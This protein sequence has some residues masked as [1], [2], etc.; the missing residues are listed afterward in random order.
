MAPAPSIAPETLLSEQDMIRRLTALYQEQGEIYQQILELSRLQ[1]EM[2]RG[3]RSLGEIRQVLQKKNVCLEIVKRL[4]L[5]ERQA[6]RQ[7]EEGKRRWSAGSQQVMNR[8]LQNVGGLIEEILLV[9]EKND[10]EFIKQM[11]TMP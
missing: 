2:V 11:R 6:R 10:Q 5:T 7:W 1:G 8:A 4:E 9:E 3:G